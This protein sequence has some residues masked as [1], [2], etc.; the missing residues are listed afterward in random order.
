MT[1]AITKYPH[2]CRCAGCE[3]GCVDLFRSSRD[4]RLYC[5]T[6]T[7]RLKHIRVE[8]WPKP[9]PIRDFDYSVTDDD[10]EPGWPLG[11]GKTEQIAITDY[12]QQME[13]REL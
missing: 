1:E 7:R 13:E 9:I 5:A 2:A 10:Y 3:N 8:Y 12:L 11:F 4:D 6:C